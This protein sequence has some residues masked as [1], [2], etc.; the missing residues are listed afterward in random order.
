[1][2][3]WHKQGAAVVGRVSYQDGRPGN[4]VL[5]GPRA[6]PKGA[7]LVLPPEGGG[8]L[9]TLPLREGVSLLHPATVVEIICMQERVFGE[10]GLMSPFE[11]SEES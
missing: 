1:M 10:S 4:V 3:A 2:V 5:V 6:N 8:Q 11:A 7:T 9:K